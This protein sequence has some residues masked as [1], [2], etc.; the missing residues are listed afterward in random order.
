MPRAKREQ[1]GWLSMPL[2][3]EEDLAIMVEDGDFGFGIEPLSEYTADQVIEHSHG[4]ISKPIP[5]YINWREGRWAWPGQ[6]DG[7]KGDHA[8]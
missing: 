5:V 2:V 1:I 8:E 3:D 6:I 7:G 4:V